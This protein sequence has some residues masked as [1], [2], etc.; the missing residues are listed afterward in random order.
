[1]D[2]QPS[3]I[4][5]VDDILH[6]RIAL[7]KVLEPLNNV[8]VV[9]A[10]SGNEALKK[11]LNND[12]SVIL[13][14]VNMPGMDGYE[15]ANLISSSQA[16]KH[17]P[18]V[19]LTAHD[20]SA[21][22]VLRAYE[23]GAID[24]LTKPI[25]STIL[26]NKVKQF[27]KISQLQAKTNY[28]KSERESILEAA[29]QGVIKF[30][31]EGDIEFINK[32]ACQ[33]LGSVAD[34]I[35]GSQFNQWFSHMEIEPD[36][37]NLFMFLR[38]KVHKLGLYQHQIAKL[39]DINKKTHLVELTCTSPRSQKNYSMIV[40]FQ[41][42]SARLEMESELVHLANYDT[43]TQLAN[44]ACFHDNLA[45]A[46]NRSKRLEST[47]VL[48]L[49]DLDRFKQVNDTLGHDV[50]DELLQGVAKRLTSMLRE[51]D[52]AA[53]LGGD[54]FAILIEDS[55]SSLD[56]EL[57]AK[58]VV[59]LISK[60]FLIQDKEIC[61]ETS[62]GLSRSVAGK[63]DKATLLKWADIALY[64]AKAVGRNCYQL[65]VPEMSVQAQKQALIQSQLRQIIEQNLLDVHYQGQF[66]LKENRFVGF[67]ALVRWPKSNFGEIPISPAQF[68]PIAEQSHLIHELGYQVLH[69]AC[70]VLQSWQL[71]TDTQHLTLAVNL[72]AKQ[73]NAY[74]F[75]DR[76]EHVL[77]QFDFPLAKL[78]FEL[79]ETAFLEDSE[80]VQ[81][82]M[83]TLINM[84][85]SLAL[86][87]FGTG[88]SSLNY[89]QN[90]PFD[91]IKIDRCFIQRLGFCHKTTALVK[92]IIT[93]A[94]AFD[95]SVVA[96]GVE[97]QIQ[98]DC[99]A[100]LGCNKIQGFYFSK[101]IPKEEIASLISA[102]NINNKKVLS[103]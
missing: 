24:Y 67:E 11:L 93:I 92:A 23:A 6:N 46:I 18:I 2:L 96:E 49:L 7:T 87:D 102:T 68:I 81:K 38:K 42:I 29:G 15:V 61:I 90:L 26:L 60:P 47:V 45:R 99:I 98:L 52:L 66:C 10:D 72:S 36:Y 39:I 43:L 76:L 86:D 65:F 14:D 71:S 25:E 64:E 20:S 4:L 40:L 1:M 3:K 95:M 91:I 100:S 8:E 75:L 59:S 31:S 84:G 82:C 21:P 32:K 94:D 44:R 9:E 33:M 62:I 27:V 74:D 89:L 17:T 83:K 80:H 103:K 70:G 97:N 73:L 50:G 12:F 56:A 30:T 77:C 22:D 5:I 37:D 85:F 19:M 16:H 88:Y 69:Q 13:L 51:T 79:T 34:K 41:D 35:I 48:L 54:E 58:K 78:T 57:L 55:Q 63:S 101:P 28:L 53:R